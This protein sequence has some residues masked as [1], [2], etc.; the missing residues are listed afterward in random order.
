LK[1]ADTRLANVILSSVI[2]SDESS[3][4]ITSAP[5]R[6]IAPFNAV[7]L[8]KSPTPKSMASWVAPVPVMNPDAPEVES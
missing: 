6:V 2:E 1:P 8:A 5:A 4:M 3:L 7:K